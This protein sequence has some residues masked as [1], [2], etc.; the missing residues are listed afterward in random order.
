MEGVEGTIRVRLAEYFQRLA[1]GGCREGEEG[2]ILVP[3]LGEHFLNEDILLVDFFLGL[4]FDFRILFQRITHIG[5]GCLQLH[6]ALTGLAGM[7]LVHDDGK[8]LPGSIF[9]FFVNDREFLKRSHNDALTIIDGI[10]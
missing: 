5:E 4:A 9:H 6:G 2:Q 8:V 10:P 7:R 3:A 1:L